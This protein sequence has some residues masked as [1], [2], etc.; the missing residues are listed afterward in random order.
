MQTKAFNFAFGLTYG[1]AAYIA[2]GRG[3]AMDNLSVVRLYTT[4][5]Q[6]H[7]H[8][9]MELLA[10]LLLYSS[11]A[12]W[13]ES[14]LTTYA[15]YMLAASLCLSPWIFNP[16]SLTVDQV[17]RS[18]MEWQRWVEGAE[19]LSVGHGSWQSYHDQRL[20]LVRA[21]PLLSKAFVLSADLMARS[22]LVVGTLTS[23]HLGTLEPPRLALRGADAAASPPPPPPAPPPP[24]SNLDDLGTLAIR[25]QTFAV[26]LGVFVVLTV[27]HALLGGSVRRR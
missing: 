16:F 3:Y 27:V 7:V 13:A 4:Y 8:V 1:R 6:S 11:L 19:G 9:G 14:G 26:S 18:F 23:L 15:C 20:R 21:Q 25:V 22:L 5:A 2:T 24:P 10:M 17:A 12:G